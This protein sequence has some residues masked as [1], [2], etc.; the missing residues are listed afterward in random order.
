MALAYRVSNAALNFVAAEWARL[1][2]NDGVAVFDISPGFL[3]TG[4]GDDGATGA[5][6][7]DKAAMG[8][9]DP[10]VGGKFCADVVER[11][12]DDQAWPVKV[13]RKDAVQPW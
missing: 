1:L 10:A 8:A 6:K 9:L 12:R 13:L 7:Y 3:N 11:K 4:L 5:A 2:H